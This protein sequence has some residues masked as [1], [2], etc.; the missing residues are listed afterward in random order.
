MITAPLSAQAKNEF[1]S[2]FY[3]IILMFKAGNFTLITADNNGAST[4]HKS[5]NENW[6]KFGIIE[7]KTACDLNL[8]RLEIY[9][10]PCCSHCKLP[11]PTNNCLSL[12]KASHAA[13]KE[14][15]G[16]HLTKVMSPPLL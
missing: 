7:P 1:L 2:H 5:K 14:P 3:V 4:V 15:L 12:P 10:D 8:V 13:Q 11:S 16:T 6:S 9:P